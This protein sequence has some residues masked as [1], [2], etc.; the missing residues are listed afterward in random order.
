MFIL[1]ANQASRNDLLLLSWATFNIPTSAAKLVLRN[2][3]RGNNHSLYTS[4]ANLTSRN[5]SFSLSSATITLSRAST[6][7]LASHNYS[8]L[9]S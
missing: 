4:V 3:S 8:L 5:D 6:A 2:N 7:N 9:F 1:A